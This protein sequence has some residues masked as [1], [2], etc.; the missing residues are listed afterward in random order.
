MVT[1]TT[2]RYEQRLRAE[3]AQQTRQRILDAVY[4]RLREAPTEPVSIDQSAKLARVSRPTVYLVFGSRAGLFQAVGA[5]VLARG[6]FQRVLAASE[7]PDARQATLGSIRGIVEMYAAERDVLRVL[8]SMAQL[9]AEAAGGA[10]GHLEQGRSDG[11]A[12]LARELANQD[13]LPAGTTVEDATH[14][15][16]LLTSFESFDTLYTGR[17]LSA[18]AITRIL[19]TTIERALFR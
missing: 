16:C 1:M 12:D 8:Q 5:D 15:L 11:M 7:H 13:V 6:G 17:Q 18:E 19:L 9:D 14:L 2:R 10:I 3:S 4:Q